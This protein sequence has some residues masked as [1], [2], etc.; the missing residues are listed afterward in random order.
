MKSPSLPKSITSM[1]SNSMMSLEPPI[2]STLFMKCVKEALQK[3]FLKR[4]RNS[5]SLQQFLLSPKYLKASNPLFLSIFCTEIS[6]QA[7]Y[8][9]KKT[10]LKQEIS[11]S[12]NNQ[13]AGQNQL[14]LSQVVHCIWLLKSFLETVMIS[15][16]IFGVQVLFSMSCFMESVHSKLTT[17]SFLFRK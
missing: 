16:Q 1:Q 11:G 6:N 14:L 10:K 5:K 4:K 2:I 3:I 12:A 13:M 9:S 8:S 7:T 17:L 15:K